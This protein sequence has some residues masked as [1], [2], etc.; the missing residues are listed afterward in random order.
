[1]SRS[2]KRDFHGR[3]ARSAAGRA[4]K[5]YNTKMAAGHVPTSGSRGADGLKAGAVLRRQ[6]DLTKA[7][8]N[9]FNSTAKAFPAAAKRAASP[10]GRKN[11]KSAAKSSVGKANAVPYAR[12]SPRSITGGFDAGAPIGKHHRV[13]IGSYVR[14]ERRGPGKYEKGTRENVDRLIKGY[15]PNEFHQKIVKKGLVF[16]AQ[17]GLGKEVRVGKT[18]AHARVGTSKSGLPSLILRR[19]AS[20]KS[21]KARAA[22]LKKYNA[23]MRSLRA[24]QAKAKKPRA[25]RRGKAR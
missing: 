22:G 19:G 10:A 6:R 12:I 17:K 3:F 1:M 5:K 25:Q 18:R 21:E 9:S 8:L 2:Y 13:V 20:P 11:I 14:V 16:A 4:V 15:V 23:D 7:S 24:A